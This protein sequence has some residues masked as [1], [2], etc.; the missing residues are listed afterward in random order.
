MDPAHKK[1]L[2]KQGYRMVGNHSAVKICDWTRKSLR[3]EGVC[4]K[5][6][7]YGIQSHRCCQ[8]TPT[9]H[10]CDFQC[11]F[12]WRVRDN[13]V[14]SK[15]DD[16][17]TI[18]DKA[19]KAQGN[20]L[21]GFGGL[22]KVNKEKL[23]EAKNPLHFAIS[24]SGETLY[25]PKLSEL[26]RVL[27]KRNISTFVVSNGS[28]PDV[29]KSL[30]KPTQF[31]MSLDSP[32]QE[33]F[34]EVNR[35]DNPKAWDNVLR[36]LDE[37]KNMRD[38]TRTTIRITLVKSQNDEYPEKYAALIERAQ[39]L[40]V[41]VKGYMFVGASRQKL[42]LA[43]MPRHSEVKAFAEEICKHCSYKIID[44]QA[45]SRVILLMQEDIPGRIMRFEG[46]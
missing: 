40:F 44:E 9:L 36:S 39:P 33:I 4:Y 1:L 6:K 24:L 22:S 15:I 2:E 21:S 35:P 28:Q 12:C 3:D 16:P 26:I 41:E 19:I 5:Q 11:I 8:M 10:F 29:M 14:P 31:Y 25:Y 18:I 20:L 46:K 7:F 32:N 13:Y 34:L 42:S 37:L 43:N 30:E 17:E 38:K 23:E 27:H 45:R